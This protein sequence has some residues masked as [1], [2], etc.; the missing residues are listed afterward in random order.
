MLCLD[1]AL[2]H[3]PGCGASDVERPHGEL[4]PRLA[5]RLRGDNPDRLAVGHHLSAGQV[6]PIAQGTHSPLALA[7]ERGADLH[8]VE[9]RHLHLA[10][11]VLIDFL[12]GGEDQVLVGVVDVLQYH[13]TEDA[14]GKPVDDLPSLDQRSNRDSVQGLAIRL[15]DDAV[16]RDIHQPPRKV[17]GIGGLERRVSEPLPRPVRRNEVL[18]HREPFAE[19]RCDG[20]LDDLAGG[21]RHESPHSGQLPHLLVGAAGARVRHHVD[22]VEARHLFLLAVLSPDGFGPHLAKHLLGDLLGR[23]RPD[24]DHLVVTLAVGDQPLAVLVDDGLDLR[25][26]LVEESRLVGRDLHVVDADRE[27]GESRVM[28][29]RGLELVRQDHGGLLTAAAVGDVDQLG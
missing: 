29:P 2:L 19:V 10:G 17:P 25:G 13:P 27:P 28:E 11:H 3:E 22:G 7:G 15:D 20:G 8:L 16:L 1:V 12:V 23:R 24:V 9:A 6:A 18:P 21:L 14:V 26:R 4:R 5:D